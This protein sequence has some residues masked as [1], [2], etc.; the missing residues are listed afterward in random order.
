MH[1]SLLSKLLVVFLIAGSPLFAQEKSVKPGINKSFETPDVP[2]FIERFEREGRD[3]FD[4]QKQIL[5]ALDLKQGMKV[6]DVGAGTGL[7]TRLFSPRVG[8]CGK[9]YAVDISD[10]FVTHIQKTAKEQRLINIETVVCTPDSVELPSNT[11]DLVF[12]CDTYHHFEYPYKTMRSIHQA[13]KQGGEVVL[14]D[15]QRVEGVSDEWTM[16][17][18]RAGQ[19]VFTKEILDSG[20]VQIDEKLDLLDE[21]YFVRFRKK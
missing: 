5:A 18:V 1:G 15:F 8:S 10:E 9:V 3:V 6:A 14:I 21:S 11:V 12:I 7:F 19:S 13:L 2:K 17:H 20:F 4:H 16:G